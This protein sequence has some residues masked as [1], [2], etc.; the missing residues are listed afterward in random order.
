MIASGK[1]LRPSSTR[2]AICETNLPGGHDRDQNVLNATVLQLVHHR[3]PE[4]GALVIGD[5][6][7][8]NLP[9]A[10]PVDAESHVNSLVFDHAAIGVADLDPE[11]VEDHDRIHPLQRPGPPFPDL[12]QHGVARH[13]RSDQWRSM[14]RRG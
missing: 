2:Q 6:Q 12:V 14:A 5:P 10:V 9:K 11:R 8:Q 3:K 1:P 7:P 4:L 13:C